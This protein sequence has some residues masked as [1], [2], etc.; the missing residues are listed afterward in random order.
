MENLD[1]VHR[2]FE[3]AK[4]ITRQTRAL[5]HG[6]IAVHAYHLWEQRGCSDGCPDEDWYRAE[7]EI[8]GRRAPPLE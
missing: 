2:E 4:N 6:D 7:Q 5:E 1:P 3:H 8:A